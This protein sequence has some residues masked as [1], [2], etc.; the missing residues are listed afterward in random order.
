MEGEEGRSAGHL[1]G[2]ER[3]A[4]LLLGAAVAAGGLEVVDSVLVGL[5]DRGVKVGLA[6]V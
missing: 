6:L 3:L 4:E 2:P 5:L 1:C